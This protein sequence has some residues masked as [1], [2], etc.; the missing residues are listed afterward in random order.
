MR[1][2]VIGGG[3][4]GLSCAWRL[5]QLGAAVLLLE[6]SPRAGGV[7]K[8]VAPDGC[9][10]E[11]GPQSFLS[12]DGLLD[13]IRSVG[14]DQEL[15][16][17]DPKAPRYVVRGGRLESVPLS[18]GALLSSPL[19]SRRSK[20][21]LLAEPFRRR[22]PLPEDESVAEFVRREFSEELL[23]RLVAPMVSGI[24]AG[25]PE[26]LSLRSAF[27]A[28]YAWK[29]EH[30]S[31]I[32]GAI[33]SRPAK[34]KPASTLCTL[35]DGVAA[36]PRRIA[37]QL[38][39]AVVTGARV[40]SVKRLKANGSRQFNIHFEIQGRAETTTADAVVLAA[41]ADVAGQILQLVSLRFPALLGQIAYA[42]VGVLSAAYRQSDLA[43]P[44]RGFGFLVPRPERLRVLGTIWNSS[45]F[46]GRAPEGQVV[47]TSFIGGAT[48]TAMLDGSDDE[49]RA[50]VEREVGGVLGISSPP[51]AHH[52]QRW[53][54]AIP[55]YNLGHAHILAALHEELRL[56]PGL[57]LAGNYLEGPAIGACVAL[58]TR[59]A[60]EAHQYVLGK[61]L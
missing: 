48:D 58:G 60:D 15:L 1:V 21:A 26:R 14:L 20:F 40:L 53:T 17:A 33:K 3:I 31:V 36:L 59:M 45:L 4:S 2:I 61:G 57:F 37:E 10:F 41:P 13:L 39:A 52:L 44:L 34:D 24:Y 35:R 6:Q 8:T 18:P 56:C 28:V 9:L 29:K 5:H 12:T 51:A 54:R 32:R 19:L 43:Q 46:P 49:I 55:Q 50:V 11:C 38:G 42:P 22:R 23:E 25:D 30:G 7:I 16:R 27:P 47:L